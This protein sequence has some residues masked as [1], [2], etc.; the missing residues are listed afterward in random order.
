MLLAGSP[1]GNLGLWLLISSMI[2]HME[3]SGTAKI[4]KRPPRKKASM[5]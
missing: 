4:S 2:K 1:Q 5:V 3:D